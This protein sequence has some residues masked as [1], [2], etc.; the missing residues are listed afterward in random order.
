MHP[1]SVL[2]SVLPIEF[3]TRTEK[4]CAELADKK[5]NLEVVDGSKVCVGTQALYLFVRL[6]NV[7]V[8]RLGVA[9][10]LSMEAEIEVSERRV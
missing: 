3:S 1:T 5:E 4:Y 10:K 7:V 6:H 9:M 8:E 2:C